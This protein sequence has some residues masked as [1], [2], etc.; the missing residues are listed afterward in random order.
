M[1]ISVVD[2]W[3]RKTTGVAD[4]D[5]LAEYQLNKAHKTVQYAIKKSAFYKKRL[6][7]FRGGFKSIAE[8]PF[9]FSEDIGRF[10]SEMLCVSQGM[11]SKV[12]TCGTSGTTA[13]PKRLFFTENDKNAT[14]E[15]FYH[16]MAEFTSRQDTVLILFPSEKEGSIGRLLSDGLSRLGAKSLTYGI[17]S[18]FD[19]LLNLISAEKI[20]VITGLPQQILEL[21]R[22]CRHKGISVPGLHSVL[23]SA[24]YAA[25]SLVSAVEKNLNCLVYEHYGMTE[26]YFGGGVYSKSRD[27]YHLR[28]NDF[29]FEIVNPLTGISVSPGEYGELVF[30]SLNMEAMPLIRYRTGDYARFLPHT[31]R[32][33]VLGKMIVRLRGGIQLPNGHTLKITELDEAIFK[34]EN[35]LDFTACFEKN[36][37]KLYV[38]SLCFDAVSVLGELINQ[39]ISAKLSGCNIEVVS[40]CAVRQYQNTMNKRSIIVFGSTTQ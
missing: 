11:V 35:V 10:S 25:E 26:T 7:I 8:L 3:V 21:S 19:D 24:D 31:E 32:F 15:F 23:L 39:P 38:R 14:I 40:A 34:N 30:T 4:T 16:G 5:S 1:S 13:E 27:G 22:L 2:D 36:V 6:E 18:D 12:F 20:N 29:L 33:P 17:V 28:H 9:T 37:L